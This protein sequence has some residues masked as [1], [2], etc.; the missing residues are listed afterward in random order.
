MGPRPAGSPESR[1]LAA[2]H[3]ADRAA[4][5]LP[6]G[7]GGLRNVIGTVRA[8]S[9]ATSW[10]AP[11]TTRRTSPA[12]WGRT[13]APR[14]PPSCSS[15][16]ARSGAR[17]TRSSSCSSTARRRRAAFP[18]PS[19]SADGLR[20]SKVAA[21]VF[22]DARA[23]VLLDFVGDRRLTHP[24]RGLLGSGPLA[25]AARRRASEW[26]AG[27]VV[28]GHDAGRRA[29]R[30]HPVPARQGVPSID[31]I[32]FDFPCWHRTLRRHVCRLR[33]ER[34]RGRRGDVRVPPRTMGPA[35]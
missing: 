6:G 20:G 5:A 26:A 17:G 22:R 8:A 33:A 2:P 14:A 15:S 34:G 28:P 21:P 23:M 30:P 10:S 7:A 1:R 4:R 35:R 32:D 9:P 13:T 27:A 18:T 24:A 12:S 25:A 31:L 29:R 19:S 11:T 3:Q 16:R